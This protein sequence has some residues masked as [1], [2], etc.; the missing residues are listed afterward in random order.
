MVDSLALCFRGVLA[1]H[2]NDVKSRQMKLE[3]SQKMVLKMQ[4]EAEDGNSGVM[5]ELDQAIVRAYGIQ[6]CCTSHRA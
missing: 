2:V 3:D 1:A 6:P 4:Q 5:Q